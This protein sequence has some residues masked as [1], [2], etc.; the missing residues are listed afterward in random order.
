MDFWLFHVLPAI[1][2]AF[3]F[4]IGFLGTFLP[5]IPGI[6]IVWFAILID[7]LWTGDNSVTWNFFW[8]ATALTIFAQVI[9]WVCTYWGVKRFGGTW[10]G[11]LGA[12]IGLIAG[13][14]VFA[15]MPLLG[16]II[17]PVIGAIVGELIGGQRLRHA[18]KAGFGTIIGG[19]IAFMIK[20][21]IVSFM[22]GGFYYSVLM[23]G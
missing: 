22:I 23:Q 4:F 9:D 21:A 15:P 13:P 7:K 8:I 18:G 12:I 19:L 17:G 16:L 14:F 6:V 2:V 11:G 20:L 1:V 10:R 5:V 3:L